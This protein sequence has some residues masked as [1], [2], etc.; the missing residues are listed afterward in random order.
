MMSFFLFLTLNVII[1]SSKVFLTKSFDKN[2]LIQ[3]LENGGRSKKVGELNINL[4][5]YIMS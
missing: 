3:T 4:Y 1:T 5:V 2:Q